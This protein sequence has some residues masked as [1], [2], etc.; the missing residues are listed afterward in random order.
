MANTY[1]D[2]QKK[3]NTY[4]QPQMGSFA[5]KP[6]VLGQSSLPSPTQ[7]P[8]VAPQ[9]SI[10][11]KVAPTPTP[12][13]APP[14]A[15]L[16]QQHI[17]NLQG[18][19]AQAKAMGLGPN[20]EIQMDA[21]GKVL[22]KPTTGTTQGVDASGATLGNAPNQVATN[23]ANKIGAT[24][25]TGTDP[26]LQAMQ[27]MTGTSGDDYRSQFMAMAQK[28]YTPSAAENAASQQA[29]TANEEV[30][31]TTAM[32]DS[33]EEDVKQSL[34][35]V[36]EGVTAGGIPF[37]NTTQAGAG[38]MTS[39][40]QNLRVAAQQEPLARLL[41]AETG[42]AQS[43]QANLSNLQ[44]QR[45]NLQQELPVL[46]QIAEY[47]TPAEKAKASYAQ[48][49]AEQNYAAQLK[50]KQPVSLPAG[51]KL[52]DPATGKVL[53]EGT[54]K[55]FGSPTSGYFQLNDDG[56]TSQLTAGT[57]GGENLNSLLSPT[58]AATLG[59]PYGTTKAQAA[60]KGI[61]PA[62]D[63]NTS[64]GKY[65]DLTSKA[66]ETNKEVSKFQNLAT[67]YNKI[68]DLPDDTTD[69]A[70]QGNLLTAFVQMLVPGANSL[71]GIQS[72][73]NTQFDSTIAEKLLDAERTFTKKGKLT[74][75][76]VA[77]V[78]SAADYIYKSQLRSYSAIRNDYVKKLVNKGIKQEDAEASINDYSNIAGGIEQQVTA[79]GYDYQ[80]M[81]ADGYNDDQIKAATGIQ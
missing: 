62:G 51:A 17:A 54:S 5:Q 33:L 3:A 38:P 9:A 27:S 57:G 70:L 56:T 58:E 44:G 2:L 13:Q 73:L 28:A 61:Q 55:I 53:A 18:Q 52:V 78:K 21:S 77:S 45:T 81:K 4:P 11:P 16:L 60:A 64:Q 30:R 72:V 46:Q 14:G 23:W 31:K 15:T 41:Q 25:T 26:V 69:P 63:Y 65:I 48:Y 43:A 35:G 66:Y 36:N 39:T 8:S 12:T 50:E 59:V 7:T 37:T 40:Q 10:P 71:R 24:S 6:P 20:D 49:V 79:A 29:T 42:A 75:D 68:V 74:P 34:A 47:Q 67:Q 32:L 80:A 1:A 19:L 22:P 76:A